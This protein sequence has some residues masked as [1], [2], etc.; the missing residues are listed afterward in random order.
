MS[1][2]ELG[3]DG[4]ERSVERPSVQAIGHRRCYYCNR[5]VKATNCS[6][7]FVFRRIDTGDL[8][9]PVHGSCYVAIHRDV[10]LPPVK[11]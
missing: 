9:V 10:K 3:P 4:D 1:Q 7:I 2:L 8:I 5:P 11:P 6:T